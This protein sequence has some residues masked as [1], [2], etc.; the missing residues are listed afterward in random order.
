[1]NNQH[2]LC[3]CCFRG[4]FS[5]GHCPFLVLL[6]IHQLIQNNN[7]N[8]NVLFLPFIICLPESSFIFT[9]L[10]FSQVRTSVHLVL[11][12]LHPK[13][14]REPFVREFQLLYEELKLYV[15]LGC[16]LKAS[17]CSLIFLFILFD[18][19]ISHEIFSFCIVVSPSISAETRWWIELVNRLFLSFKLN[20]HKIIMA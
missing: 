7:H 16:L 14:R 19:N 9:D 12:L 11:R 15:S 2:T 17:V 13:I 5:S 18:F 6:Q 10:L 4:W 3:M 20:E 8:N 1:M